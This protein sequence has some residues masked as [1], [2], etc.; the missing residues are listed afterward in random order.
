MTQILGN[1]GSP[2]HLCAVEITNYTQNQGSIQ[3]PYRSSIQCPFAACRQ[4]PLRPVVKSGIQQVRPW[5]AK[6]KPDRTL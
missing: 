1:H 4:K 2:P 6:P 5:A 3:Y